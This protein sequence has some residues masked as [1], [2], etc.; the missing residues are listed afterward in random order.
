[1]G[2]TGRHFQNKQPEQ[3]QQKTPTAQI[4]KQELPEAE[5]YD[6]Y[7]GLGEKKK[8]KLL[9]FKYHYQEEKPSAPVSPPR[10][11]P[12]TAGTSA[13]GSSGWT[14]AS[15]SFLFVTDE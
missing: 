4:T 11:D 7:Q 1:M 9:F 3:Q 12:V 6:A 14:W 5:L 10:Q 8:G 13:T 15:S 2:L